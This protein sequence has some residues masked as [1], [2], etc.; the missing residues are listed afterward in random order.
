METPL[1]SMTAM[2]IP[3]EQA[4][5]AY[6]AVTIDGCAFEATGSAKK[7][8]KDAPDPSVG[9]ALALSRTFSDLSE[10]LKEYAETLVDNK[11]GI[12][13]FNQVIKS[14]LGGFADES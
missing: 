8:P 1:N 12:P 4:T 6:V 9:T 2:V 13:S 5:T 14:L 3:A 7:H 11:V 10:K